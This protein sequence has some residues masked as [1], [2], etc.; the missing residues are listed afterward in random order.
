MSVY[1]FLLLN[2]PLEIEGWKIYWIKSI[3]M[4]VYLLYVGSIFMLKVYYIL[5]KPMQMKNDSLLD[6]E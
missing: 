3:Q 6:N 2:R 4:F 1:L 5:P